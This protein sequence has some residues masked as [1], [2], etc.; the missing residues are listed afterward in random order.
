MPT[1]PKGFRS[2][3]NLSIVAIAPGNAIGKFLTFT[4]KVIE[5]AMF[6]G[7]KKALLILEKESVRLIHSGYYKPAVDSGHMVQAVTSR[8]LYQ[9]HR[10]MA[11]A[12]GVVDTRYAIYVHEGTNKMVKRPFLI[13]AAENKKKEIIDLYRGIINSNIK[14]RK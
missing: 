10:E 9:T 6:I 4:K 13:D 11:G 2:K 12:V 14:F 5:P 1:I 3:A 8:V 7:L